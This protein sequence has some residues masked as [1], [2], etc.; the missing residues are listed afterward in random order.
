MGVLARQMACAVDSVASSDAPIL[1]DNSETRLSAEGLE[2][3]M[4]DNAVFCPAFRGIANAGDRKATLHGV[5]FDILVA[6]P[7]RP[8]GWPAAIAPGRAGLRPG[9]LWPKWASAWQAF[10]SLR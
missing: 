3:A 8:R 5:V 4:M 1:Y 2:P 6:E 7:R 10:T 9:L